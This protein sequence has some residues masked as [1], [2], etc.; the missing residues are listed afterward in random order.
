MPG[1]TNAGEDAVIDEI[2][3]AGG[4]TFPTANVFVALHTG[5]P[6]DDGSTNEVAGGSYAR[7]QADFNAASGGVTANAANIDFTNMPATTVMAWSV[8]TLVTGGTCY[9]TGWLSTVSGLAVVRSADL[10]G[11]DI[12]T[13]AHG[14]A[15]DDRV[16]FE[17]IEGLTTP[18]GITLGTVYFVLSGG[19][20]TDAFNISATSGGAEI[21]ITA[22]GSAIWRKV[23]PKVTNSGDTFRIATGDLDIFA[24]E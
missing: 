9:Q 16:V 24:T 20:T 10:A 21:D 7:Q 2:Y 11:N 18:A 15:A 12:Q 4:G 13:V 8:W 6:G 1:L 23:T 5:D 17:T 22:A 19:L 14:L 3:N